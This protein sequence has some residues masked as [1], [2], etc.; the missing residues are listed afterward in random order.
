MKK[1]V[2]FLISMILSVVVFGQNETKQ[3]NVN[4]DEVQV[5]PP[6]FT[7]VENSTAYFD[8]DNFSLIDKY[9]AENFVCPTGVAECRNEGTEVIEFTVN[10]DG[11]LSNFN[12]INSLCREVDEE[13]IRVLTGTYGMWMPGNNNGKPTA[14]E[15]EVSLMIGDYP[16]EKIVNHFVGQAEKYF[17]LASRYLFEMQKPKKAL[18]YY[19]SGVRYMPNDK[20]LLLLR[21]ICH[22]ELGNKEKAEKDWNRIVSLGG[23]ANDVDLEGLAEMKGYSEMK[24]ILAKNQNK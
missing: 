16:Q 4:V 9:V 15:Q 22:F 10:P 18:K 14:M 23:I 20:A 7:G 5:T 13:M 3:I 11:R 1:N 2:V 6:K 12:V 8:L 21:G 17:E 24:N 19:D